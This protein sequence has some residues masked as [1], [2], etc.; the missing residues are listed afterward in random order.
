MTGKWFRKI[1]QVAI[2]SNNG[3]F[4]FLRE[5]HYLGRP[6]LR[7]TGIRLCCVES[8]QIKGNYGK[9]KKREPTCHQMDLC[10]NGIVASWLE[11]ES[12]YKLTYLLSPFAIP[13][14][15]RFYKPALQTATVESSH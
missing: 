3:L 11:G 12:S 15:I 14:L 1:L 8:S 13:P 10:P 5:I 9:T 4:F 2:F 7:L 6:G